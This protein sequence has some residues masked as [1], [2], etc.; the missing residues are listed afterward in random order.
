MQLTREELLLE[1]LNIIKYSKDKE[2]FVREFEAQHYLEALVSMLE[3]LPDQVRE[4]LRKK[5]EGGDY[6]EI[7]KYYT[8]DEYKNEVN[9][10]ADAAIKNFAEVVSPVLTLDQKQKVTKL[11]HQ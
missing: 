6:K 5:M 10:V 9:K 7:L 8:P 3:R 4:T 11:L 2:K 1:I